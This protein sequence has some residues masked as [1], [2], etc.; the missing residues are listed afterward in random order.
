MNQ[1][2]R[3]LVSVLQ[4]S[5]AR[6]V[7]FFIFIILILAM[8]I[9]YVKLKRMS[10]SSGPVGSSTV[11]TPPPISSI[12]GVSQPS[13][14]YVKLQEEQNLAL[15]REATKKG[16]AAIPTIVRT[17]YLDTGVSGELTTGGGATSS[18]GCG[19]EELKK[20]KAAGVTAAEL[21]CRGCSLAALKAAGFTAA[22]LRAAGFSAKD[23]RDAG[24]TAA[25]LKAAGFSAS[26][27]AAAGFSAKDLKDAGFTAG[28]L[29]AAG[30]SA[31][32]LVDAGFSA[33][34]LKDAGF[35]TKEL[36]DVGFSDDDLKSAG[37]SDADIKKGGTD[38]QSVRDCSV[39]KL[40]Q[41]RKQGVSAAQLKAMG[42]SAAALKAAGYTAAELRAAGF[43]AK[44]LK[45]AGFS[46]RDLKDAGFSAGELRDAGFS[47]NDLKG[48]GFSAK[49]LKD[50]GF[51][52]S[53][54]LKAGFTPNEL[55][56]A[57]YSDGD[58]MRAG[59][60]VKDLMTN[61]Q[62]AKEAANKNGAQAQNV[63][64]ENVTGPA[65][66]ATADV[67]GPPPLQ[68]PASSIAAMPGSANRDWQEQLA[69]LSKQQAQQLSAQELK[70]KITQMQSVMSTQANDLFAS[71]AP[72]PMQ[73]F[74]RG[75]EQDTAQAGQAQLT[76]GGGKASATQNQQAQEEGDIY[77]AG[78]ILFAVL[79]TGINS[80]ETSPIMATIVQ[81]DLQGSKVLGTFTRINKK[82]VLQFTVLNVPK[83][84]KSIAVNG[85]A[86]DPN[87][88]RTAM[89]SHVD[90][91]YML[92]Y[93]TL[94]ASSFV[95]GIGQAIQTS[96]SSSTTSDSGQ[97]Q[98]FW[99]KLNPAQTALVAM[100]NVGQQFSSRIAPVFDTPPTVEVKTGSGIGLLLM[101]DLSV[102]KQ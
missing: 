54:L 3:N 5:K 53:D 32:D 97:Q 39:V 80:D 72:L 57:G 59:V 93:G 31:K 14:E 52:A 12:P 62:G 66:G 22:E 51:S 43:S 41:A 29:K 45:D 33:K 21:R 82:V 63:Q 13:R 98:H 28:E 18:A 36:K 58:L 16:T 48:A 87:T 78:T 46:A 2:M 67:N 90:S 94:F 26:D 76:A 69:K 7:V 1:R 64:P 77:K 27:L 95:S 88:A 86:I 99:P 20:A 10:H 81:G 60:D 34:E 84:N 100:G 25:E 71:W 47:A 73:Q 83:L 9:G 101:S 55:K 17:T 30:F 15:E 70:E 74:V 6:T 24:F 96:G 68:G 50:A 91:H 56:T 40:F 19:V 79:D 61:Q 38:D 23:L 65:D 75:N 92:R 35:S 85:V 37:I 4:D 49:E 44:D 42:C 102:P 11:E 89:A 8:G